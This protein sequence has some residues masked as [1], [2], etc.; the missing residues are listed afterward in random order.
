MSFIPDTGVM[1]FPTLPPSV[2]QYV[3]TEAT[4][5]RDGTGQNG[6]YYPVLFINTFWQLRTHMMAL[7]ST[8]TE[9]PLHIDLNNLANWKFNIISNMDEA[10]KQS[11]R[12]AAYGNLPLR[13]LLFD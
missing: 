5:A 2:R 1:T 10:S 6:W 3:R 11:A 7:N 13:A 12:A 4:G 8:V 9:V